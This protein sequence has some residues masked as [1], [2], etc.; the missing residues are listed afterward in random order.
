[1]LAF[2]VTR[3]GAFAARRVV[4]VSITEHI[5]EFKT[6]E[7]IFEFNVAVAEDISESDIRHYALYHAY[8]DV[9]SVGVFLIPTGFVS[10]MVRNVT[11]VGVDMIFAL[12]VVRV[13]CIRTNVVLSMFAR[14]LGVLHAAVSVAYKI[15]DVNVAE[16][17]VDIEAFSENLA[18]L[19]AV[20]EFHY[21]SAVFRAEV[22]KRSV[23]F[24]PYVVNEVLAEQFAHA[25][26]AERIDNELFGFVYLSEKSRN[27]NV[28]AENRQQVRE[29]SCDI[30]FAGGFVSL[31]IGVLDE[32]LERFGF[33]RVSE[34]VAEVKSADK[35][36]GRSRLIA[37]E[38]SLD[39]VRS[40]RPEKI[41]RR[42][43]E[44]GVSDFLEVA[45]YG[46]VIILVVSI[47]HLKF[48]RGEFFHDSAENVADRKRS[49]SIDYE[50]DYRGIL[51]LSACRAVFFHERVYIVE[52]DIERR[53]DELREFAF[54]HRVVRFE[55]VSVTV[56]GEREFSREFL[57]EQVVNEVAYGKVAQTTLKQISESY[58]EVLA[59][60][61]IDLEN[62]NV[63]H[64]ADNVR[65]LL[66]EFVADILF[67]VLEAVS[68]AEFAL[69]NAS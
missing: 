39:R 66:I 40:D 63:E 64:R 3:Y 53:R 55:L 65:K 51:S 41:S 10:G 20:N 45:R 49:V 4:A 12:F 62:R 22:L 69:G 61:V 5:A 21:N 35:S 58:G 9:F 57:R 25:N 7:H 17:V 42:R 23:G 19:D 28:V 37:E 36:V 2:G 47:G 54:E 68:F 30:P 32:S 27:S 13:G 33:E 60:A 48:L 26:L 29:R 1:M 34:Y 16:Y 43:G 11:F 31:D 14:R 24:M 44:Y 46:K 38:V 67:K 18:E 15:S 50:V 59:D 8:F 52:A 56:R 6:A